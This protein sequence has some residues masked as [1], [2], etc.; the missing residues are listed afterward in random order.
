VTLTGLVRAIAPRMTE[1]LEQLRAGRD[2]V[3]TAPRPAHS[4]AAAL[5]ASQDG[6]GRPLLVITATGRQADD[7][8]AELRGLIE[9]VS[10]EVYP[11]WE[12]LPHERLR[13]TLW[14][15]APR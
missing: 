5:L 3:I 12:T 9:G 2:G 10:V 1:P 8:A 6:A 4:L 15:A 13:W 11:S 14:D 7:M